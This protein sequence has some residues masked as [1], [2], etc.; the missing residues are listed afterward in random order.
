MNSRGESDRDNA[1]P[2]DANLGSLDFPL[3]FVYVGHALGRRRW[4]RKGAVR[5]RERADLAKVELGF[6]FVSNTLYLDERGVWG[7]VSLCTLVA[8]D[9]ALAVESEGQGIRQ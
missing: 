1:P 5:I 2:D 7:R 9:T 8:E 6:F 3:G 4:I